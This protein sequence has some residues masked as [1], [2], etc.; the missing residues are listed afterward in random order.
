MLKDHNAVAPVRL[1]PVAHE[2]QPQNHE[3]WN[4]RENFHPWKFHEYET[5]IDKLL[6][7]NGERTLTD[8]HVAGYK[9]GKESGKMQDTNCFFVEYYC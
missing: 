1:E 4:N 5:L 6:I 3:F 8:H 2:S 9:N 7:V